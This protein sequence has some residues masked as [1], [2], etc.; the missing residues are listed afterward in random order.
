M[1]A[2]RLHPYDFAHALCLRVK[3]WMPQKSPDENCRLAV[4]E[5]KPHQTVCPVR[6]REFEEILIVGE[7]RRLFQPMQQRNDVRVLN[8]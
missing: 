6:Q 4:V 7:Q 5:I 8:P 3:S 2:L 1:Y